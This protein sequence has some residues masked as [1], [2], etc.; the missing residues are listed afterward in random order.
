MQDHQDLIN[1]FDSAANTQ[2]P[3]SKTLPVW[4]KNE[5]FKIF[6]KSLRFFDQNLFGKWFFHNFS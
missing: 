2:Q 5:D 6:K 3:A 1:D 4:T